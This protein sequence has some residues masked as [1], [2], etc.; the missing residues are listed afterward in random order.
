MTTSVYQVS[1]MHCASCS[2][3]LTKK[4]SR[5]PGI[6]DCRVNFTSETATLTV[7]SP[8]INLQFLNR[9]IGPLG[10]SFSASPQSKSSLLKKSRLKVLL[11][12]PPALLVFGLMIFDLFLT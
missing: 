4:L 2:T 8:K 9:L 5:I 11:S 6:T 7:T 1:G 10:Y 12:L 3:I